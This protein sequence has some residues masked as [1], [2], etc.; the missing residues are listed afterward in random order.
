[1]NVAMAVESAEEH[2][3]GR[4]GVLVIVGGFAMQA[5]GYG[6]YIAA[7]PEV[8][9]S[10]GRAVVAIVLAAVAAL[11]IFLCWRRWREA[12]TRRVLIEMARWNI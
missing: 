4:F 9:A 1:M 5:G 6:A 10:G 2:V 12:Q 7:A 3:G 8:H 11:I